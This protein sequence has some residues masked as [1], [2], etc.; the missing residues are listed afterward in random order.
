MASFPGPL[1]VRG[2][3]EHRSDYIAAMIQGHTVQRRGKRESGPSYLEKPEN[4]P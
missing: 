2:R 3:E 1:R 4:S